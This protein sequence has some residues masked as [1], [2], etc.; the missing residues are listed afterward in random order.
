ME[1]RPDTEFDRRVLLVDDDPAI[2]AILSVALSKRGYTPFSITDPELVLPRLAQC[3]TRIVILDIDMPRKD[4]LSLLREIKKFD[5]S[6]QV[7]M[8]TGLVS[9]GTILRATKLGAEECLFKPI[10]NL[11]EVVD[12]VDTAYSKILRWWG[13]LREWRA[14]RTLASQETKAKAVGVPT[15]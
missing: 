2:L 11:D 14:R 4:G 10:K 7:I 13:T 8:L 3:S 6:I 9:M 1:M 5:G 12:G 15:I